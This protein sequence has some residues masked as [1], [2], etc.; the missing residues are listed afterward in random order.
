MVVM[1]IFLLSLYLL[2]LGVGKGR[3]L[4]LNGKIGNSIPEVFYNPNSTKG[5]IKNGGERMF[6]VLLNI[7][8]AVKTLADER[9]RLY[10][11]MVVKN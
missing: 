8:S 9:V 6:S 10:H 1:A 3:L 2:I 5:C 4:K 7:S 11:T